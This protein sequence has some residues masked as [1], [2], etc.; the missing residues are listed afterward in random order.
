MSKLTYIFG[1]IL[2]CVVGNAHAVSERYRY[3]LED[4]AQN[5]VC[6]HMTQIFNKR[7]KT[8]WD[9]GWLRLEPVPKIFGTPYDQVFER[10]PGVGYDKKFI[11]AMLL[12]KYPTSPEFEAIKWR[13]TR[14]TWDETDRPAL[15]TQLD[16]DNDKKLD[17][18]IKYSFMTEMTTRQGLGQNAG[19]YDSLAIFTSDEFDP[20]IPLNSKQ[21]LQ[22][23]IPDRL[24]RHIDNDI[25]EGLETYQMRLFIFKGKTYFSAYQAFWPN[26]EF[27]KKL[28]QR[29]ADK[30][31]KLYP[32]R[33]YMNIL[34]LLPG[35]IKNYGYYIPRITAKTETVCRIR[36]MMQ[37]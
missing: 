25:G 17:W 31:D 32:E 36:M 20:A 13:E 16:I 15:V 8:P 26:L 29:V 12:S 19:G 4:G 11:F 14:V 35:G 6:R 37:K 1:L 27:S 34:V 2:L 21:V 9:K 18:I 22:G 23:Q 24:P 10:M 3:R 33:E 7:F 5:D 28:G 30:P